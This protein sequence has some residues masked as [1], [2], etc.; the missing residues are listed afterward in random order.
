MAN[1]VVDPAVD[2]DTIAQQHAPDE[3]DYGSDLDDATLDELFSQPLSPPQGGPPPGINTEDVEEPVIPQRDES[4]LQSDILRLPRADVEALL[5]T[6]GHATA[7]VQGALDQPVHA[8]DGIAE[9]R[10]G[11]PGSGK[12]RY[13]KSGDI[14][15]PTEHVGETPI[16]RESSP[17]EQPD[18][19]DTRSPIERFR[20]HRALTVTD[21]VTPAWCELQYRYSLT[22]YGRIKRTPAMKQGSKIHKQIEEETQIEVPVS[23]TTKEDRFG[24]NLWNIIQGLRALRATGLTRELSVYGVVDGD[25][26]VGK[27]DAV[28]YACPDEKFEADMLAMQEAAKNGGSKIKKETLP[29]DQ[30]TMTDYLRGSQEQ[31]TILNSQAAWSGTPARRRSAR[32]IYL[33]DVKTRGSRTVPSGKM[34]KSTQMQLMLYR[35]FLNDLAANEVEASRIFDLYKLDANANFSDDFLASMA[36]LQPSSPT[37]SQSA[38]AGFEVDDANDEMMPSA[39]HDVSGYDPLDEILSHNTLSSLWSHMIAEF[40]L[41]IPISSSSSC[42]SP[43][44]TAEFRDASSGSLIGRRSFAYDADVLEEYVKSEM[45]WWR[46]EREAQGVQDIEEAGYKCRSCKFADICT[47]RIDLDEKH[48][49]KGKLRRSTIT[50][51]AT[52]QSQGSPVAKA[53]RA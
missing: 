13:S 23:T 20:K 33:S 43:L 42:I 9:A 26:V 47:W 39:D 31:D 17:I 29:A 21:L 28:S 27:I 4:E 44:L 24:V 7:L 15:S 41:T 10:L 8:L 30:R 49:Q 22:K 51:S 52:T 1:A 12:V 32:T 40:R 48:G 3:S 45:S 19:N 2:D 5:A 46:G 11:S 36:K 50:P 6:L 16:K 18:T 35:R 38:F 37:P 25:V 53:S 14:V 34:L